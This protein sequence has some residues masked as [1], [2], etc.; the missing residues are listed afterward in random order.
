MAD[1]PQTFVHCVGAPI[2]DRLKAYLL[3]QSSPKQYDVQVETDKVIIIFMDAGVVR[4][5][6]YME[7]EVLAVFRSMLKLIDASLVAGLSFDNSLITT[8]DSN[9]RH[10]TVRRR[11][12][13]SSR[14]DNGNGRRNVRFLTVY[15]CLTTKHIILSLIVVFILF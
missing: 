1:G 7:V 10:S 11:H 4:H 5:R 8:F 13:T 14:N 6:G 3:R 2:T 15:Y 9:S 12:S